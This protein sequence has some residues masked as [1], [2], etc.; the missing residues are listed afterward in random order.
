MENSNVVQT[1]GFSTLAKTTINTSTMHT[2]KNGVNYKKLMTF[3]PFFAL[4]AT[5]V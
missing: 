3:T 4:V 5:N 2:C 1:T